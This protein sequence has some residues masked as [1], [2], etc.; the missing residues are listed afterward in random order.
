M[1]RYERLV[2][3]VALT[4]CRDADSA[5]DIS[6]MVFFKAYENLSSLKADGKLKS[7]LVHITYNESMNWLRKHRHRTREDNV[8]DHPFLFDG[9]LSQEE[10][11]LQSESGGS[12]IRRLGLL[13]PKHRLVVS[14]RYF[15]GMS[16]KEIARHVR[17]S[18]GLVKNILFRS[19][20]KLKKGLV[21]VP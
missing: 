19:L 7:W 2:F 3:K 4:Y 14:L 8:E 15:D 10:M 16:I 5:L 12:L 9:S 13:N 18:E 20:Q 6:Q 21:P 11:L 1:A 17:C